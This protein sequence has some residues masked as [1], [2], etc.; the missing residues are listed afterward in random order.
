MMYNPAHRGAGGGRTWERVDAHRP[1]P[2][3]TIVPAAFWEAVIVWYNDPCT[4]WGWINWLQ[5][6]FATLDIPILWQYSQNKPRKGMFH[7][8]S[9]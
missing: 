2:L 3:N 9:E 6:M 4:T 1:F 8:H 5:I 7:D